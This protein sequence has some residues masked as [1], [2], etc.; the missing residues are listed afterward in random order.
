[1]ANGKAWT[2]DDRGKLRRLVASGMTD[3]EI[4][5]KMF[6]NRDVVGR[7]RREL[8]LAPGRPAGHDAA[9]ARIN[10]RR[11]LARESRR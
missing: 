11:L 7:K 1:M 2:A 4:G 8:S 3:G 10:L 5:E 6:R 9:M